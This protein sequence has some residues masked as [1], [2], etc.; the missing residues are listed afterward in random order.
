MKK[1]RIVVILLLFVVLSHPVFSD[2]ES[3]IVEFEMGELDAEDQIRRL[4]WVALGFGAIWLGA[5]GGTAVYNG[6]S[7]REPW[8]WPRGMF[9]A[10]LIGA[11]IGAGVSI[12]V[13]LATKPK[14]KVIPKHISEENP[15][16][17]L[18]GFASSARARRKRV[19]GAL[20]GC[21]V[22]GYFFIFPAVVGLSVD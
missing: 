10:T 22:G 3:C 11:V 14:P 7:G 5:V 19:G 21:V 2:I 4:P 6:L 16:C 1:N 15:A 17:Y 18:A 20:I 13:P 12:A 9:V 8:T